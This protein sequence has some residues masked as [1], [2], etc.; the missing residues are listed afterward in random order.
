MESRGHERTSPRVRRGKRTTKKRKSSSRSDTDSDAN[1]SCQSE[2]SRVSFDPTPSDTEVNSLGVF[3]CLFG[4]SYRLLFLLCVQ[5]LFLEFVLATTTAA[6]A[7]VDTAAASSEF[8]PPQHPQLWCTA[9]S[10]LQGAA[11]N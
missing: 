9:C 1:M 2:G 5:S 10:G 4:N 7:A 8:R 6:A 3:G 11:D